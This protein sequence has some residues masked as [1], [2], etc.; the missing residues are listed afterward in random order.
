MGITNNHFNTNSNN[1]N[2]FLL[3]NT[4]KGYFTRRCKNHTTIT[5]KY[6]LVKGWS[7]DPFVEIHTFHWKYN[8]LICQNPGVDNELHRQGLLH[9]DFVRLM[10]CKLSVCISHH[11]YYWL[12][13]VSKSLST[14]LLGIHVLNK[15]FDIVNDS[16]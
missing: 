15:V 9:S 13:P 8:E 4:F 1:A 2:K 10:R 5:L 14:S 12:I 3:P 6:L 7:V 16:F 11:S